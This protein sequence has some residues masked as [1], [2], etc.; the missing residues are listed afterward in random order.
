MMVTTTAKRN[1]NKNNRCNEYVNNEFKTG[2]VATGKFRGG[3]SRGIGVMRIY[4][5]NNKI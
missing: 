5:A 2:R 1:Q 3:P 4:M